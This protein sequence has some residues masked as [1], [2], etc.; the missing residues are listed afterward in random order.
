M[1]QSIVIKPSIG[2]PVSKMGP[3]QFCRYSYLCYFMTH[4]GM[5][6]CKHFVCNLLYIK[7]I[8]NK[9]PGVACKNKLEKIIWKK[10]LNKFDFLVFVTPRDNFHYKNCVKNI[11]KNTFQ[12]YI[13]S[14]L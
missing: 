13:V 9:G 8:L 1:A 2:N 5:R 12:K 3:G 6:N 10:S 14:T 4:E 11:K 7:E